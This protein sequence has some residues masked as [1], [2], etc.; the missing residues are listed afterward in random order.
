MPLLLTKVCLCLEIINDIFLPVIFDAALNKLF[1]DLWIVRSGF[2]TWSSVNV[3]WLMAKK[4]FVADVCP[5][6]LL[7]RLKTYTSWKG[8]NQHRRTVRPSEVRILSMGIHWVFLAHVAG[9]LFSLWLLTTTLYVPISHRAFVISRSR[10]LSFAS[11][12]STALFPSSQQSPRNL[13]RS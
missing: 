3:L 2:S 1:S 11:I 4:I 12:P 10:T 7:V 5:H 9:T 8:K 6:K 13:T